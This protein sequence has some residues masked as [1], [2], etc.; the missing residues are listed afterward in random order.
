MAWAS[1]YPAAKAALIALWDAAVDVPVV[2]GPTIGAGLDG[3][4][5]VGYQDE[6]N[7]VVMEG[8]LARETYGGSPERE[9]YTINC[10]VG[11][12][13]GSTD[14]APLEAA[15]VVLWKAV[16]AVLA[17]NRTLGGTTMIAGV[18]RYQLWESQATDGC[19]VIMKFSVAIDASTT[20]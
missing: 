8:T 7:Q 3:V 19:T 4:V 17:A 10:S 14:I 13:S 18:D 15:V 5:T 9:Q 16:A 2:N 11:I 6:T 1:T 20:V 12:Q